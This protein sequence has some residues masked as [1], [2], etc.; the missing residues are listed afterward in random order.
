MQSHQWKLLTYFPKAMEIAFLS[1]SRYSSLAKKLESIEFRHS[2]EAFLVA[3]ELTDASDEGTPQVTS[4]VILG[5]G[6][7]LVLSGSFWPTLAA[8]LVR[9][10]VWFWLLLQFVLLCQFPSLLPPPVS[11]FASP[12]PPPS[13]WTT[14]EAKVLSFASIACW[15]FCSQFCLHLGGELCEEDEECLEFLDNGVGERSECWEGSRGGLLEPL[16]KFWG[17]PWE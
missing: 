5:G 16:W 3:H 8:E 4:L 11:S 10:L 17:R 2:W 12:S 9:G 7:D 13:F 6:L 14:L 15:L 1:P